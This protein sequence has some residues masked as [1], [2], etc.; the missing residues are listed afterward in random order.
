MID[1]EMRLIDVISA[2]PKSELVSWF[3]EMG[4]QPPLDWL[5]EASADEREVSLEEA[6]K[7]RAICEKALSEADAL[8]EYVAYREKVTSGG[9]R[10]FGKRSPDIKSLIDF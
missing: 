5:K 9:I 7:R 4:V 2:A 10:I 1:S 8:V 3:N 6:M